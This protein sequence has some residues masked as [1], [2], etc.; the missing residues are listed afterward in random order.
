MTSVTLHLP[1]PISA[2]RYWRTCMPKG[3]KA[4]GIIVSA[5]AKAYK[6]HV[7]WIAKAAG[8]LTPFRG[9]VAVAYTLYPKRPQD[10]QT[11]A[12]KDALGWTDSVQCIDLDNAQK[13]L[14]DALK[15]VVIEDDRWVRRIEA[16]RADPDGEARLIVTIRQLE[17]EA[18]PQ[19]ALIGAAA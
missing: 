8:V 7:G 9:R 4:P 2:N 15:G 17:A 5:E 6:A 16:Q 19:L 18:S 14:F 11:R 12:R 10:W 13:V 3:F 1:Y